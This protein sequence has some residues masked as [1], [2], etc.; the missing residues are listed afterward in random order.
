MIK[1]I[2]LLITLALL[3]S[4]AW[5]QL[6]I[7]A[8]D[9]EKSIHCNTTT[10]VRVANSANATY[11]ASVSGGLVIE[12]DGDEK[13]LVITNNDSITVSSINGDGK[14]F[15]IDAA[16]GVPLD[17]AS[18]QVS[19]LTMTAVSGPDCIAEAGSATYSIASIPG[20]SYV[21]VV[22]RGGIRITA[23]QG[24]NSVTVQSTNKTN[25]LLTVYVYN[26]CI[27]QLCSAPRRGIVIRKIFPNPQ[28]GLI[29]PD[30]LDPT[31]LAAN[32]SIIAFFIEPVLGDYS[33]TNVNDYF[34]NIPSTLQPK[35]TS[36]DG[37]ARAFKVL[38]ASNDFSVSVT[39]GAKCNPGNIVTKNINV[40]PPTP[41][42]SQAEYCFPST[43]TQATFS[44]DPSY[45]RADYE[46]KWIL[47]LNWHFADND[48]TSASVN[49]IMDANAGNITLE[50][51]N[52]GCGH[53]QTTF[54]INRV[55][56][57]ASISTT[58]GACVAYE[59][60]TEKTYSVLPPNN[61][62]YNWTL[63]AGW[64]I[65]PGTPTNT[66]SVIV[67]PSGTNGGQ[68]TAATQGCGGTSSTI[69]PITVLFGPVKP[70]LVTGPICINGL[71]TSSVL[72][73]TVTNVGASTYYWKFPAGWVLNSNSAPIG[74]GFVSTTTN[75][76]SVRFPTNRQTGTV[77][78]Y[79]KSCIESDTTEWVIYDRPAQ[80]QL[81]GPNP[82]L[83]AT[84]GTPNINY[85]IEQV[86]NSRYTWSV[87][88]TNGWST[89]NPNEATTSAFF[90]VG[91]GPS[92]VTV[93]AVGLL[94]C[95][96][97]ESLPLTFSVNVKPAI[98]TIT[99]LAPITCIAIGRNDTISLS[100]SNHATMPAGTSY[101]WTVPTGSGW[102]VLSPNSPTTDVITTGAPGN[103]LMKV[104][105]F[106][107]LCGGNEGS[108]NV[109]ISSGVVTTIDEF[110]IEPGDEEFPATYYYYA[111][112]QSNAYTYKWSL[113]NRTTGAFVST[114]I[115]YTRNYR[116]A[117]DDDFRKIGPNDRLVVEITDANGCITTIQT[118]SDNFPTL[119]S[120]ASARSASPSPYSEFATMEEEQDGYVLFPNPA[121]GKATLEWTQF[122]KQ[123]L[124]IT[125]A[126]TKGTRKNAF[127]VN[128]KKKTDIDVSGYA[129]G[130]YIVLIK[131]AKGVYAKKLIIE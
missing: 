29:G 97:V 129:P 114:P 125:I 89:V 5:A 112:I 126:D 19:P 10:T 28:D 96:D 27:S 108:F 69:P 35:F 39:V 67:I 65:K 100:V 6:E 40:P 94:G 87:Q 55:I 111:D 121:R 26:S 38:N 31:T 46:Y 48:S 102:T 15:I 119:M 130:L 118:I 66:S 93:K 74:G 75:S 123:D 128:N 113:Y 72:T 122:G 99:R 73:Y 86:F 116:V 17:S 105:A 101:T 4:S 61:N 49:V 24:T 21:W 81:I 14:L 78:V 131:S 127:V 3:A 52:A 58:N 109:S 51:T 107:T 115:R 98:P 1:K 56:S 92:T 62:Q 53:A 37:S 54:T 36:P 30:C 103:Y 84:Q 41:V 104:Q 95:T 57:G 71:T 60:R 11:I 76:I 88:N 91:N 33:G 79:A 106:N 124:K 63:P 117:L 70:T 22:E 20:V 2:T 32:D 90:N 44:V 50:T 68:I 8:A 42:L 47:P 13:S 59:D 82:P 25:S 9:K 83:C 43:Q 34:W 110:M 23:G 12:D 64:V 77:S 45:H 7:V 80:P 18:V 85:Q 120:T 16:T